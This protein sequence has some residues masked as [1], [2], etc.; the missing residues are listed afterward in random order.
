MVWYSQLFK[1]FLQFFMIYTVKGLNLV[2]EEVMFFWNS[3]AFSMLQQML[4]I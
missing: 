1:N 3:L 4:D 2:N